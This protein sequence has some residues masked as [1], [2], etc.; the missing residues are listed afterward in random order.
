[1]AFGQFLGADCRLEDELLHPDRRRRLVPFGAML[2]VGLVLLLLWIKYNDMQ[3]E[4][5]GSLARR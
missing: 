2:A 3:I 1:M 4:Q 5:A